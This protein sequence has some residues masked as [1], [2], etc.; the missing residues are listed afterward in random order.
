MTSSTYTTRLAESDVLDYVYT[1][2][3]QPDVDR[4]ALLQQV[5]AVRLERPDDWDARS[6]RQA[7]A[8]VHSLALASISGSSFPHWSA[9]PHRG[10]LL[11]R[12]D[13]PRRGDEG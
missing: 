6:V 8:G 3:R 12:P 7:M 9:L 1:M 4:L 11:E 13:P 5:A 2:A 10:Q